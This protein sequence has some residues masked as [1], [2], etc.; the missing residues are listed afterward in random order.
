MYISRGSC[1]GS[2]EIGV[3]VYPDDT[4]LF[5]FCRAANGTHGQTVVAADHQREPSILDGGCHSTCYTAAHGNNTVEILKSGIRNAARLLDGNF[6][7]ALIFQCVSQL[8]QFLMKLSISNRT[9]AHIHPAP[10][11]ALRI[12][13][14][15]KRRLFKVVSILGEIQDESLDT[16]FHSWNIPV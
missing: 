16:V 13:N 15:K 11:R 5:M 4:K 8:S 9:R 14:L 10:I 3:R 12:L 2:V 6:D 7:V 1:F